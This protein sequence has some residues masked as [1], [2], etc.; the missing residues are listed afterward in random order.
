MNIKVQFLHPQKTLAHNLKRVP[1]Y[2]TTFFSKINVYL[3]EPYGRGKQ[4][5]D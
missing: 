3:Q 2:N 1:N 5:L 4:A